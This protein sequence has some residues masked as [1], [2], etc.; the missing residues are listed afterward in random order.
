M[1]HIIPRQELDTLVPRKT[2]PVADRLKILGD[3]MNVKH[4]MKVLIEH[5]LT[6]TIHDQGKVIHAAIVN[7]PYNLVFGPSEKFR[8]NQYHNNL[9][10]EILFLQTKNYQNWIKNYQNDK[11]LK[12]FSMIPAPQPL[13]WIVNK[14]NKYIAKKNFNINRFHIICFFFTFLFLVL[15]F[16]FFNWFNS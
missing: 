7:N 11:S 12:S 3:Y 10:L 9:D 2:L 4:I 1:H 13:D 8:R 16:C 6:N 15:N 5:N 14:D